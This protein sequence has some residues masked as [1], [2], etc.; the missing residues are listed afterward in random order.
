MT[1]FT[2]R[3]TL[4][5]SALAFGLLAALPLP[6]AVAQ[7]EQQHDILRR[8]LAA[9]GHAE[10]ADQHHRQHD[11]QDDDQRAAETAGKILA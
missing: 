5:A 10:G 11:R 3:N 8:D 7:N 6:Q 4:L 9:G 1:T 2:K